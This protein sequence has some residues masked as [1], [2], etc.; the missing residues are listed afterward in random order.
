MAVRD[1]GWRLNSGGLHGCPPEEKSLDAVTKSMQ[2][3]QVEVPG[4]FEAA[5]TTARMTVSLEQL[6]GDGEV[7]WG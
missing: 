6:A 3:N 5:S 2:S 7:R 4:E 1:Q